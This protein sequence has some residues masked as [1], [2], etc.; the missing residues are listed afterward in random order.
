MNI[1][2]FNF[3]EKPMPSVPRRHSFRPGP[4]FAILLLA[5]M[6]SAAPADAQQDLG[7]WTQLSSMP[8]SNAEFGSATIGGKIYLAGGFAEETALLVYDVASDSFS[9]GPDLPEGN[10]HPGVA[11]V[12]GRLYVLGGHETEDLVQIYD[13]DTG[14]WSE[15]AHLPTPRRAFATVVLRG[16]IHVIGGTDNP[17]GGGGGLAAHEVY[18]PATDRWSV[19]APLLEAREHVYGGAI[20]SKIYIAAGRVGVFVPQDEL[21]IYDP[22]R[23]EWTLGPPLIEETSGHA[24]QVVDEQLFVFGGE[25]VFADRVLRRTQRY[26]PALRRWDELAQLP[27]PL[28]GLG[29]AVHRGS[30]YLFGGATAVEAASTGQ[31]SVWRFDPPKRQVAEVPRRLRVKVRSSRKVLLKWKFR[32]RLSDATG[33]DIQARRARGPFRTIATRPAR[34]R[35]I[36]LTGLDAGGTYAFRVRATGPSGKGAPSNTVSVTMPD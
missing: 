10:H 31:S 4:T 33:I 35:R 15:G 30:I 5:A 20:G 29:S 2:G 7:S 36:V 22:V 32:H 34:A 12:G 18:D 1:R 3:L 13:P 21:Q 28:H 19:A 23:D 11:T 16:K 6:V 24:A 25:L 27:M 26:D 8:F 17:S 9:R 14:T